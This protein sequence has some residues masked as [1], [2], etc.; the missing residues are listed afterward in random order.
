MA[1]VRVRRT[2][3]IRDRFRK[4]RILVDG[5]EV[6]RVKRGETA[7][8]TVSPGYHVV[9]VAIDWKRSA[10]IDI[11]GNGDELV[12]LRCGPRGEQASIVRAGFS[13]IVDLFKRGEDS[14]LFLERDTG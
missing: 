5:Q 10:I 9:Q 6:A 8:V 4:Y 13:A 14:W 1:V 12:P 2:T 3:G 11:S 7:D